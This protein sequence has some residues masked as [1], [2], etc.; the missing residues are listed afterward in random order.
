MRYNI[1]KLSRFIFPWFWQNNVNLEFIDLIMGVLSV[2]NQNTSILEADTRELVGY[3]IQR[4][5]LE[6]S[7]NN[8]FDTDLKRIE[9]FNGEV[10]G[11][12]FV[13][14]VSENPLPDDI[15]FSFN[16]TEANPVD[17]DT[18]FIY[19]KGESSSGSVTNFTVMAPISLQG[20]EPQLRGWIDLVLIF[21][22]EYTIIYV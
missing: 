10:G 2:V 3:S 1:N 9:I 19:N 7:L 16:R 11:S 8:R 5:S 21:G 13:F 22:T 18:P 6:T 15:I 4:L 17:I 12:E 20:I 14:N